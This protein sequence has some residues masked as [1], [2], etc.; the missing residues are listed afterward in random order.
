MKNAT[1]NYALVVCFFTMACL[2]V[3]TGLALWN[4]LNIVA[5]SL[6]LSKTD[7]LAHQSD[8]AYIEYLEDKYRYKI[9]KGEYSLPKIENITRIRE[10]SYE[11]LI[12][13]AKHESLNS[14]L[15]QLIVIFVDVGVYWFHWRIVKKREQN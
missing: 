15:F 13:F 6:A 5:P 1:L 2:A 11:G 14:L 4:A 7:Y 12:S 3:T 9:N 10:R 8:E